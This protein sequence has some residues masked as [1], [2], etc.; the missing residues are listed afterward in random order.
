MEGGGEGIY[1]SSMKPGQLRES[2]PWI[3]S[4]LQEGYQL[5]IER[6]LPLSCLTPVITAS[7]NPAKIDIL[8]ERFNI[9]LE[10]VALESAPPSGGP[11]FFSGLFGVPKKLGGFCP[12]IDLKALNGF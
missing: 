11:G 1:K 3:I 9:L 6:C 8:Q 10:T 4:I 2:S 12:I 5:E 7:S